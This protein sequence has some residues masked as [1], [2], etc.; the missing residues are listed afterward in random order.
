[1]SLGVKPV[2]D[3]TKLQIRQSPT[4]HL[5]RTAIQRGRESTLIANMLTRMELYGK[6]FSAIYV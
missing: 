6:A 4:E 2:K 3:D 1:M 5:P